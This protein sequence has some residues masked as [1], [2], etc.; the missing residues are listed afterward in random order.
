MKVVPDVEKLAQQRFPGRGPFDTSVRRAI[1]EMGRAI[2]LRE[3]ASRELD[4]VLVSFWDAATALGEEAAEDFQERLGI[5]VWAAGAQH[6]AVLAVSEHIEA[7][8]LEHE[9]QIL[10]TASRARHTPS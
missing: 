2:A 4:E 8:R 10:D 7:A 9:L 3:F 6:R 1:H 5:A